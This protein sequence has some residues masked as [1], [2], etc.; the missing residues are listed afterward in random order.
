MARHRRQIPDSPALR[1]RQLA[2][3][4]V[5]KKKLGLDDDT[6]RDAL[7][8]LT[9]L[10]SAKNMSVAQ[11]RR[12][13]DYF[14]KQGFKPKRKMAP[15]GPAA[16][17]QEKMILGLW[18]ELQRIGARRSDARLETFMARMGIDV[19]HPRWPTPDQ[20]NKVIEGLKGWLARSKAKRGPD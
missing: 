11:R 3:I 4:H 14:R 18:D 17:P 5:A 13:L 10:R 1:R 19:T 7:E 6:Y 20:A 16:K 8:Q 15:V 2:A 9:G 12:V